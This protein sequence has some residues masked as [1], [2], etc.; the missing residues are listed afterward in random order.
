MAYTPPNGNQAGFSFA[1]AGW[2][3]PVGNE[4][5]FNI[6][7]SDDGTS[8]VYA[9]LDETMLFGDI[10]ARNDHEF[11]E[12]SGIDSLVIGASYTLYDPYP[13]VPGHYAGFFFDGTTY[14]TPDGNQIGFSFGE[15]DGTIFPVSW[16]SALFGTT[17]IENL[18]R[19]I[20]DATVGD[21]LEFGDLVFTQGTPPIVTSLFDSMEFG[22]P[23]VSHYN[24][25][26]AP[27]SIVGAFG[28]TQVDNSIRVVQLNSQGIDPGPI[29]AAS[30]QLVTRY[31]EPPWFAPL[32][33]G[34][35]LIGF[36]I[37]VPIVGFDSSLFGTAFVHDNSQST[38]VTGISS[39]AFGVAEI[40]QLD[41]QIYPTVIWESDESRIPVPV[42]Y[43]LNQFIVQ[44][45]IETQ[46]TLGGFGDYTHIYNVNRVVD[47]IGNGMGPPYLQIPIGHEIYNNAVGVVPTGIDS[48]IFG[49]HLIA[50][51]D[52][53]VP[54][55]SWLSEIIG[56][57]LV[58]YNT[59]V[60]IA[61]VGFETSAIGVPES[62]VNTRRYFPHIGMGYDTSE[63]GTAFV[64]PAIRNVAPTQVI[65]PET[66]G[67]AT[68]WFENRQIEPAGF[69]YTP[70][71][72][73]A[74]DIHFNIVRPNTM[75]PVDLYGLAQ[76]RNVT[77]HIGPYWDEASFTH[78]GA[79]SIFNRNN[80]YAIEGFGGPTFGLHYIADRR[81][82]IQVSG[83]LSFRLV[84]THVIRNEIP[85]PPGAQSI[86]PSGIELSVVPAPSVTANSLYPVLFDATLFGDA[87]VYL[88]GIFPTGIAPPRDGPDNSEVGTPTVNPTQFVDS[89]LGETLGIS[90][91]RFTPYTIYAPMGAPQQAKDNHPPGLEEPMDDYIGNGVM[92]VWGHATI[93]NKNRRITQTGSGDFMRF[94][95]PFV[96]PNPGV[97]APDGIK[98]FKYGVPRINNGQELL[99]YGFA[100][101]TFGDASI[102]HVPLFNRTIPVVGA[103]AT[104]WGNTVVSNFIRYYSP[105][106]IDSVRFGTA[107]PQHPPPPAE[108]DGYV[109]TL[110]GSAM[111]AY[112]IRHMQIEGFDSFECDD[113]PGHFADRMRVIGLNPVIG[114]AGF[115]SEAF[116]TP[117]AGLSQRIIGVQGIPVGPIAVPVPVVAK[118]N[119]IALAS[120]GIDSAVFGDV[121]RW[122]AGKIKPQGED[123]FE[124][125][126]H[127]L[128]RT[129]VDVTLGYLGQHPAPSVAHS[130]GVGGFDASEYGEAVAMAF[131]C[132]EQARALR[133]W[134]GL[135][136]GEHGVFDASEEGS[137]VV[138]FESLLFGELDIYNYDGGIGGPGGDD[139]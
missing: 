132:G 19:S 32:A 129:I 87:T 29:G 61:P 104:L 21:Q 71:G 134:D 103:V 49:G 85:D 84:T 120:Y 121:Q 34:L 58:V 23:D 1:G 17:Q 89:T 101:D 53:T 43:N 46:W 133:G 97:L 86:F 15:V 39:A 62:V 116:G 112:R 5:A 65:G 93:T 8:Y 54:A 125:G 56:E 40:Y 94:G 48:A 75:P 98:S 110:W 78:F 90:N 130:I 55:S 117:A 82:T 31:I 50:Y 68:V 60:A 45:Y 51:K 105:A 25:T 111:V 109:A 13:S 9:T 22:T 18:T 127:M 115:V 113:S 35:P 81:Q 33:W 123:F 12:P 106:G 91:P 102:A 118:R 80:Y 76:V 38:Q 74:F 77:P 124:A 70:F 137:H 10:V 119:I 30:I 57:F 20:D 96:S 107:W 2:T 47:L 44:A 108:P 135:A 3:P 126:V 138:G 26:V 11:L 73:L 128:A 52:R 100:F 122:E 95:D 7:Q 42:I 64:A 79:T 6:G 99:T 59:A 36:D 131:G 14:T 16:D 139:S 136:F 114:P 4:V 37:Q 28:T 27:A 63:F 92:P 67:D 83:F 69:Q 24:R 88:N 66:W 41:R 72:T